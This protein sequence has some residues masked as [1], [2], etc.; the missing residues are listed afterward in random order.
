M[1]VASRLL[2]LVTGL[3]LSVGAVELAGQAEQASGLNVGDLVPEFEA[4]TDEG[5]IWRSSD[6]VGEKLLVV[7]FY[8]AAMTDGCTAQACAFRDNRTQLQELGAEV[9]GIS[10]DRIETLKQF[11]GSNRINFPLLS[12][13]TGAVART[14]G[15]PTR[16]GGTMRRVIDGHEVELTRDVTTA[17]WTFIIGRDGRILYKDTQVNPEGDGDAV[18]RA[19]RRLARR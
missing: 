19:I 13:S 10:G 15:V 4:P 1:R 14:F 3:A 16:A 12:D 6:H 5:G 17:R 7:Y 11:R 9:V 8:P 2:G 18:I